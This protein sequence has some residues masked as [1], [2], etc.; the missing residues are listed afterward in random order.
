MANISPGQVLTT[1]TGTLTQSSNTI[2]SPTPPPTAYQYYTIVA[3]GGT[4]PSGTY[5]SSTTPSLTMSKTASTTGTATFSV[6][7]TGIQQ[8]DVNF[9]KAAQNINTN[10]RLGWG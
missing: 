3:S 10:R 5:I 8:I 2:T 4:I 1:F 7:A 6:I 9:V